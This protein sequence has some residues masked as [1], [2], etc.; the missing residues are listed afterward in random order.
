MKKLILGTLSLLFACQLLAIDADK[1]AQELL[2]TAK[3]QASLFDKHAKPFQLDVDF[4]AQIQT[5]LQGHL[6]LKWE[7][8]DHWWRKIMMGEFVQ[9][10][11]RNGEKQYTTRNASF[12]PAKIDELINLLEFAERPEGTITKTKKKVEN[13]IEVACL[14]SE[15]KT[16]ETHEICV[17]T[18]SHEILKDEWTWVESEQRIEH[19]A[20]YSDFQGHRYPRKLELQANG[21]NILTATVAG[22]TTSAFDQELLAPPRGAIERRYCADMVAPVSLKRPEPQHPINMDRMKGDFTAALTIETDGSVGNVHLLRSSNHAMDEAV[23]D[24]VKG[25]RYKPAMCGTEPVVVD[26]TVAMSFTPC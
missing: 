1:A 22:L 21:R 16:A 17:N 10:D 15:G 7:S 23:L 5:P 8:K 3:L 9:V 26:A 20:D 2:H 4:V 6:T 25:R 13:G 19:Y 14:R 24:A 18:A 12:T 11:V